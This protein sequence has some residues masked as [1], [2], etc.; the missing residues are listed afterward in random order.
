MK[1]D[2]PKGGGDAAAAPGDP[3]ATPFLPTDFTAAGEPRPARTARPRDAATLVLWREGPRG[4][5]V[6]MG[7]RSARHRFMP[8]RLVFPGGR[9]DAA[10]AG[11][12]VASPLRPAT[13]RALE[14]RATPRLAQAIGV[15]AARELLEETGLALGE[16]AP[17]GGL[18]PDLAALDYLCRALTPPMSPVRFNARFLTAPATAVR[19]E[20]NG[21][22]ELEG[23]GW[24]A[25][26]GA[27][28]EALAPITAKVLAEFRAVMAMTE[29]ARAARPLIWYQ[30]RDHR[31][32]EA[33][34]RRAGRAG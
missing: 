34:G 24:H 21:S 4:L 9:V 28:A 2:R 16:L 3:G 27:P 12:P 17:D 29:A 8:G 32:L 7:V 22:G 26:E 1:E 10:D 18:R 6:L 30:G 33:P 31:R 20:L 11:A 15:A 25:V 23:L 19:G 13:R 14:N 5:E